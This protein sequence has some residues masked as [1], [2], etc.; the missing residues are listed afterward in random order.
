ML[1]DSTVCDDLINFMDDP[2]GLATGKVYEGVVASGEG[3]IVVDKSSKDCM[4]KNLHWDDS[5]FLDYNAELQKCLDAY[6][7]EFKAANDVP[8]F[9]LGLEPCQIQKYSKGG[10]YHAWHF[11]RDAPQT[12]NRH[13]VFMTYLN[14][15]SDG[16][17]TEFFY[18]KL[19][20]KPRKG[21]TLIWPTDWTHRHRGIPSPTQE[22]YIVTGWY[23]FA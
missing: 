9:T 18:Q 16:G 13:L 17:E 23:C 8:V 10:G 2:E 5:V 11:E 6:L 19:K 3:K 15:V 21:M 1:S 22:K 12:W 7:Q 14:D 20:I 4:Q